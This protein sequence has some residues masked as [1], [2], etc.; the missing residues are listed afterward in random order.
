MEKC[1]LRDGQSNG[2]RLVMKPIEVFFKRSCASTNHR[3]DASQL[4]KE[5]VS[6]GAKN[7]VKTLNSFQTDRF[8][9]TQLAGDEWKQQFDV[10]MGDRVQLNQ[11]RIDLFLTS[12]MK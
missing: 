5:V 10:F 2:W 9:H 1:D 12:Q 11:D 7:G 4:R 8:I 3:G 6:F